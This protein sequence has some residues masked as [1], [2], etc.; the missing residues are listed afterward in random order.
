MKILIKENKRDIFAK[1]RL[2]KFL[3]DLD[4]DEDDY[5]DSMGVHK[6]LVFSDGGDVVMIWGDATNTLY[7]C[8]DITH[9]IIIF[10]YTPQQLK[11]VIGEWFSETFDLPVNKVH[12][13]NKSQLN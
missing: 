6:R 5:K 7:I 8:E 4:I 3:S 12:H 10:T 2:S 9:H 1:K 11:N 13:V